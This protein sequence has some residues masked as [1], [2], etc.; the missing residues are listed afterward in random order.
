MLIFNVLYNDKRASLVRCLGKIKIIQ[1]KLDYI[2]KVIENLGLLVASIKHVDH[3]YMLNS[4][5]HHKF[6]EKIIT[7]L[8]MQ[9]LEC[10]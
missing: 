1:T 5:F 4:Y 2:L 9:I 7:D 10:N 3:C 8:K 6:A